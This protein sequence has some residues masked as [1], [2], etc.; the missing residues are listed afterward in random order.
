LYALKA[1]ET[2]RQ[3]PKRIEIF[4]NFVGIT[5][6]NIDEK[7]VNFYD[8]VKT[9]SNWL[10]NALISFI[11]FQKERAWRGEI[12]ESTIPIITSPLNFS[13]R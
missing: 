10:Q 11:T 5:G 3:Y 4:L 6:S 13:A 8:Q 12:R 9:N 1:P 2:K 7:L